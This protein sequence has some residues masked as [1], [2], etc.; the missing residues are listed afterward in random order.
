[1]I[2][3][4]PKH[5]Y[6]F[7]GPVGQVAS[8]NRRLRPSL[9]RTSGQPQ[10]VLIAAAGL[11]SYYLKPDPEGRGHCSPTA[12][13]LTAYPGVQAHPSLSRTAAESPSPGTVEI[14]DNFDTY[15]KLV[16]RVSQCA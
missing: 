3:T 4:V 16:G 6:R 5:G 15:M 12:N 9:T 1:M 13:P 14:Q 8:R 7:A 10:L 2:E 11:P